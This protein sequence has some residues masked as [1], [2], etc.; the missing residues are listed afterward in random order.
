VDS[1]RVNP[2]LMK[3]PVDCLML[4]GRRVLV[5]DDAWGLMLLSLETKSVVRAQNTET[6]RRPQCATFVRDTQ[7]IL[8][9]MRK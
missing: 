4:P 7:H 9:S 6:W 3:E 8:V 1:L 2:S 5:L